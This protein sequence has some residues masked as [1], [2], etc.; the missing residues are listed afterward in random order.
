MLG[1]QSLLYEL[2]ARQKES[3]IS[4]VCPEYSEM[5]MMKT[6]FFQAQDLSENMQLCYS[7]A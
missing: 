4:A 6:Q 1:S 3:G 2:L 5:G 7:K